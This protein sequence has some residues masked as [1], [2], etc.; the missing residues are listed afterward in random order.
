LIAITEKYGGDG[1]FGF[2]SPDNSLFSYFTGL[3][4]AY[5]HCLLP[6]R[7]HLVKL[8]K[9]ASD[10]N[11]IISRCMDRFEYET[12]HGQFKP[13]EEVELE[14]SE[15]L[16]SIDWHDFTV[17]ETI[18]F[19]P[20]IENESSDAPEHTIISKSVSSQLNDYT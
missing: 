4:E 11:V 5:S 19:T 18:T 20:I 2:L 8:Q 16:A 10:K 9:I 3:V 1:N 14:D 7:D 6:K 12:K 15:R 13:K 17:V